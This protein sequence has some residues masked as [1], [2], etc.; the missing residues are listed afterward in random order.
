M[1]SHSHSHGHSHAG[2][3]HHPPAN[4][5]KAFAIGAL[6]NTA[7][8][9][10]EVVFGIRAGSMSLLADAGHNLSDVLGLLMAWGAAVWSIKPANSTHTYGFRS[11]SILAALFNSSLL[12]VAVGAIGYEA[13][14]RLFEATPV[15]GNVVAWV[16]GFGILVN[17]SVAL[18]FISGSKGD[19][20]IRAAFS[21]LA[22]DA[23]MA[24]GVMIGG[25]LITITGQRLIDPILSLAI[26]ILIMLGTWGLFK[27]ALKFALQGVPPGMK[28][29]EVRGCLQGIPAVEAV[30]D[31]HVW[32]MSTTEVALTAHLVA[33]TA[34]D[35]DDLIRKAAD[36][37]HDQFGIHHVT[38]Q[39]EQNAPCAEGC[40]GPCV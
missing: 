18:M 22:A 9:I 12:L 21:H 29:E 32:G 36:A 38:L 30:H 4:F 19:L 35:T 15:E 39:I 8:V 6:L 7:F 24:A 23:V 17:G 5:G 33:P 28:L 25:I 40:D 37:L 3:H 11:T 13:V 31:L 16:A 20:N 2:H 26:V 27:D 1:H 10:T 34:A 14:R